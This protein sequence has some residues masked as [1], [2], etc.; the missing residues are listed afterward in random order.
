MLRLPHAVKELV[1]EWLARQYPDRREKVLNRVRELRGGRLYDS[2]WR[3][4]QR[5]EGAFADQIA[6][7]F[8]MGRRR[9]GIPDERPPLSI[10]HFRRPPDAGSSQLALFDGA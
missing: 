7:L 8:E 6:Q 10:A 5:G 4:R 2:R 9:A 3:V 1:D